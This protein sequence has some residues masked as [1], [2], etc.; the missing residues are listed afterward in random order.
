MTRISP[1][2]EAKEYLKV[3]PNNFDK[4]YTFLKLEKEMMMVKMK[5][6]LEISVIYLEINVNFTCSQSIK[7]IK[8]K[9]KNILSLNKCHKEKCKDLLWINIQYSLFVIKL[10]I[11]GVS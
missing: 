9:K 2:P 7:P 3:D 6:I 11:S 8:M 1:Y 10:L 5:S 4:N